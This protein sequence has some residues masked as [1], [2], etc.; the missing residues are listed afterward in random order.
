MYN[1][2]QQDGPEEFDITKLITREHDIDKVIS[3][4]KTS[5]RRN[6]RYAD[7]GDT[8]ELKGQTFVIDNVYQQQLKDVTDEIAQQEGF[9]SLEDFKTALT[10]I[11]HGS[12]WD[13]EQTV[14]VHEFKKK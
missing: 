14:W 13:P 4:E 3:G 7:I 10:S 9:A 2:N 5:I 12:V 1:N 8:V 11:H 6:N